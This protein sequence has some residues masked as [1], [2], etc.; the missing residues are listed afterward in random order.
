M[1]IKVFR[2]DF[3]FVCV[4]LLSYSAMQEV[5]YILHVII[6]QLGTFYIYILY[7]SWLI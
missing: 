4:F 6:T 3:F 5:L 2:K 1:A 7:A